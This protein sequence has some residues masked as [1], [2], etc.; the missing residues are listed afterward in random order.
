LAVAVAAVF[1][2]IRAGVAGRNRPA[3]EGG[4]GPQVRRQ[5]G[6]LVPHKLKTLREPNGGE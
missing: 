6:Y 5:G 4:G 1:Q 3:E 2:N